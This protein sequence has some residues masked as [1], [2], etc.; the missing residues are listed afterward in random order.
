[1][2]KGL[3]IKSSLRVRLLAGG[4]IALMLLC[5]ASGARA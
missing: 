4:L 5:G 1:M 3:L 2:S